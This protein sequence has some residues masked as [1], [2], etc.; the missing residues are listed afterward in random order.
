MAY[1]H[2]IMKSRTDDIH[3]PNTLETHLSKEELAQQIRTNFNIYSEYIPPTDVIADKIQQH[4]GRCPSSTH[5]FYE[6]EPVCSQVKA[7]SK[8][9]M[10]LQSDMFQSLL[11]M[12]YLTTNAKKLFLDKYLFNILSIDTES[13]RFYLD[14]PHFENS[15]GKL[16]NNI[17]KTG[18]VKDISLKKYKKV[19][20]HHMTMCNGQ[21]KLNIY[22]FRI[23]KISDEE[24]CILEKM[25]T[26]FYI[27]ISAD[28]K[29]SDKQFL[30]DIIYIVEQY[31]CFLNFIT[32]NLTTNKSFYEIVD[33]M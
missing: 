6:V 19:L 22:G 29:L 20:E 21:C 3:S 14:R 15:I 10:R 31:D 1:F 16:I 8:E 18:F 27:F 26:G 13:L 17:K 23:C 30:F 25:Y 11:F 9:V 7:T 28:A 2:L 4:I 12:K 5:Y 32:I 24:I 33:K